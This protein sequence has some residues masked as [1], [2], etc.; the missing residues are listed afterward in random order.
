MKLK[1]LKSSG[2]AA[3]SIAKVGSWIDDNLDELFKDSYL[4]KLFAKTTIT[5]EDKANLE[6]L[7]RRNNDFYRK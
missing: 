2:Q 3:V 6:Y 7:I 1:H 4:R 5:K